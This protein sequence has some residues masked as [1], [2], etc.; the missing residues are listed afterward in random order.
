MLA[1]VLFQESTVQLLVAKGANMDIQ[2][3]VVVFICN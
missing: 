2:D 3:N 1:A